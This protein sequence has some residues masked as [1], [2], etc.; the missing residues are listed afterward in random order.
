MLF[1]VCTLLMGCILQS[2]WLASAIQEHWWHISDTHLDPYY[3]VDSFPDGGCYCETHIMCPRMPASCTSA[4]PGTGAGPFGESEANC[5]TPVALWDA[6]LSFMTTQAPAA[7]L[8]FH[9]GD[10]GEAGL[11]TSCSPS[12]PAQQQIIGIL[13]RSMSD[14]RA[15][16][17]GAL[18]FS[19]LG[20]HDGT[21]GDVF[22][23]GPPEA[24]LYDNLTHIFGS[25][26]ANDSSAIAT[27]R[28]GGYYSTLVRPG[29]RVIALNTNYF[30]TTNPLLANSSSAA[31]MMGRTQLQ[32]VN[33]TL[34]TAASSDEAVVIIGHIPP[35]GNWQPGLFSKY[36]AILTAYPLVVRAQF[37]GHSHVD[38]TTIV[39]AC[40]VSED[41]GNATPV[42]TVT[43]GVEWCSGKNIDVGNVF[44]A[45]LGGGGPWCP[46]LPGGTTDED[47]AHLCEGVCSA[48]GACAGFT[49]YPN[50]SGL[51]GGAQ[52]CF[53]S[54]LSSMPHNAS[55]V[56]VCYAK[57]S[58]PVTAVCEGDSR[59]P[60]S[61]LHLLFTAPSLT[62]GYPP[63][64][65]AVRLWTVNASSWSLIDGS[66]FSVDIAAANA[67]G[68]AEFSLEY[69]F[70]AAYGMQDMGPASWEGVTQRM[71]ADFMR[72][73]I[74]SET[75]PWALFDR[76]YYKNFS[77]AS[78]CSVADCALPEI[79]YLNGTTGVDV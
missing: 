3:V 73:G 7:T 50:A 78:P 55:S 67:R 66:T 11:S 57:A 79:A 25:T 14:L 51:A 21:P 64:N 46:L 60:G 43:R 63:A 48:R 36:R 72:H 13:N 49:L 18:V 44:G 17:P 38:E 16:F 26:F 24:W 22:D 27:L 42:Y 59:H 4:L 58:G 6:A 75:S 39:R 34:A 45:G 1:I 32:W 52:C 30:A 12:S 35:H 54:E 10:H 69:S 15:A 47:G 74:Q 5:A 33:A 71:L 20:N 77:S 31:S 29:L 41:G 9:T 70:R 23:A 53:R 8:V 65:G 2:F 61:P 37:F 56:A 19:V 68:S 40:S 76:F 28:T 62:E